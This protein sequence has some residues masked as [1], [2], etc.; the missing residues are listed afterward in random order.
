MYVQ[1]VDGQPLIFMTGWNRAQ[2]AWDPVVVSTEIEEGEIYHAVLVFDASE[3]DVFSD[4]DGRIT[5]YL[6]GVEF[7]TALGADQLYAHGDDVAIGGIHQNTLFPDFT[8]PV[9]GGNFAGIID[10]VAL[11]DIALDDPDGDEDRSDSR[12]LDHYLAGTRPVEDPRPQFHRGDTDD[13]GA[14]TLSDAV[15]TLLFLFAS[16]SDT[17]CKETQDFDNDGS[18]NITDAVGTLLFLF[19]GGAP[20]AAPGPTTEPCGP[21]PDEKGSPGDLGCEAYENC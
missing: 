2:E 9:D 1:E 15:S 10:E 3:N 4:F 6:D 16:G 20:P 14:V 21:D 18:V 13:D 17:G 5:G 19:S 12:V 7:D 11:Y 8:N